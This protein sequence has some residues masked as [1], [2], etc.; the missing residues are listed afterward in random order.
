MMKKA[1][2][3]DIIAQYLKI[4][5]F[6]EDTVEVVAEEVKSLHQKNEARYQCRAP[7]SDHDYAFHS[8][9]VR[10]EKKKKNEDLVISDDTCSTSNDQTTEDYKYNYHKAKLTYGLLLILEMP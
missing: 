7:G 2:L 6:D 4:S 5:V 8:G 1:W 9:R 10:H 3:D